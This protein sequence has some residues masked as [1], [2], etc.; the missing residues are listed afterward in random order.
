MKEKSNCVAI[1]DESA[2][3][4]YVTS[5][6]VWQSQVEIEH[7]SVAYFDYR[8]R[9]AVARNFH[10]EQGSYTQHKYMN[11]GHVYSA[12]MSPALNRSSALQCFKCGN[13]IKIC[14]RVRFDFYPGLPRVPNIKLTQC[15][16]ITE[17]NS[18]AT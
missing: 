15:L 13:T 14:N 7:Y 4:W 11:T 1:H 3:I 18:R 17:V 16:T 2:M 8:V 10:R 5:N 12:R 6:G 9:S